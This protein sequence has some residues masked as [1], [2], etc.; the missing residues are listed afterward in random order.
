MICAAYWKGKHK[1]TVLKQLQV[2]NPEMAHVS[3]TVGG[4]TKPAMRTGSA[5]KTLS[6]LNG[7]PGK[8]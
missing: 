7:A 2:P 4:A 8:D 5:K 1:E 3:D 6:L